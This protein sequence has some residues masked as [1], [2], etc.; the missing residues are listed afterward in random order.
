MLSGDRAMRP[1]TRLVTTGRAAAK[2]AGIVNTPVYHASTVLF[3]TLADM[4][5]AQ[6]DP[7]RNLLYGRLGTP[8]TFALEDALAEIEG[9]DRAIACPSG[10]AAI[11]IALMALVKAGDHLLVVDTVYDPVR[12][13][14]TQTMTRFGVETTYYPPAI[15]AGIAA[16]MRPETRVV[17][18]ESPG[19]HS[20]EVQDIPAIAAAAHA[21]GAVV[22]LD[23]TW[24]TPLYFRPF[25]HGIDVSLQAATKYIVGHSDCEMGAIIC[26]EAVF[27]AIKA[28]AMRLGNCVGPDDCYLT[29]RGLRTLATRM[30]RHQETG[31][32]L[33]S[34]LA[35]QPEIEQVLH[36]GLPGA[37]GH[38]LWKRDFLG[39]SGLFGAVFRAGITGDAVAALVD[40]RRLFGIGFSWGG[41]ESLILPT[42]PGTLHSQTPWPYA[43]PSIRVHAGLE[44]SEDLID[45]LEE[46]FAAL[47][48]AT[49]AAT[50]MQETLA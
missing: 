3:P 8:S 33:A 28:Q 42:H 17:L 13:F 37:P 2:K 39:A 41:F 45:D 9:G 26:T 36:P 5:V 20:F 12:A 24:A 49:T 34:W 6:Q 43:G 10:M 19:S 16:L 14:L 30:P 21:G 47:R 48:Q 27:P 38:D 35:A 46:G 23:N 31:L 25:E 22:M 50:A 40:H 11:A 4:R 1:D 44:D 29:L 15:G 18:C 7:T 32:R